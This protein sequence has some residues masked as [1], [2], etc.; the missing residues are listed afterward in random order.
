MLIAVVNTRE[1]EAGTFVVA[2]FLRQWS[3]T[4]VCQS[5][6]SL[7]HH[8]YTQSLK[9][10][11]SGVEPGTGLT[12]LGGS[13]LTQNMLWFYD[14]KC[15]KI[16]KNWYFFSEEECCRFLYTIQCHFCWYF[17]FILF[18]FFIPS[19]SVLMEIFCEVKYSGWFFFWGERGWYRQMMSHRAAPNYV[20]QQY[21]KQTFLIFP[22]FSQILLVTDFQAF[23]HWFT[24]GC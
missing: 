14:V 8:S 9:L 6:R 20:I 4:Q 15:K 5:S 23:E 18:L 13:F 24:S 11:Y 1:V 17:Y 10:G 3:R 2:I 22:V 21:Q 7:W 19:I 16:F 12:H